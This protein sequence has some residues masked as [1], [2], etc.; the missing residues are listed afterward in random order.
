MRRDDLDE[1]WAGADDD[2]R[3]VWLRRGVVPLD[4]PDPVAADWPELLE[5]VEQRAKPERDRQNRTALRER[6]WQYA[7]KRPGLYAAIA[8]LE[9][10]LAIS[11]VGQQVALV[12]L[13]T[14][15][16]YAE[17]TI[18]FPFSDHAAFCVLQ[19]RPHEIW[20][21]FFASSL[22]DRLR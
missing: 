18:V 15:M 16:V 11:R 5:I 6:W 4:Y 22:E 8:G 13:P 2:R 10:V 20:A 12:F 21:R 9:R 19:S 3:R 14:G 1:P 17:T 7:E